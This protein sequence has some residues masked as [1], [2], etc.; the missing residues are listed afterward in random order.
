MSRYFDSSNLTFRTSTIFLE[1]PR[2][3]GITIRVAHSAKHISSQNDLTGQDTVHTGSVASFA[4]SLRKHK[5]VLEVEASRVPITVNKGVAVVGV[6]VGVSWAAEALTSTL[7][8]PV[9][10]WS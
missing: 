3:I 6:A 9:N 5:G 4:S 8:T 1:A 2:T 10:E 7:V